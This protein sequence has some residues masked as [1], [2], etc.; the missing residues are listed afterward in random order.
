MAHLSGTGRNLGL[1]DPYNVHD[2][3]RAAGTVGKKGSTPQAGAFL[4]RGGASVGD[5]VPPAAWGGNRSRPQADLT[6]VSHDSELELRD[7]EGKKYH[8]PGV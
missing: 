4:A 2:T 7:T 6:G 5:N 3:T 1:H 8:I